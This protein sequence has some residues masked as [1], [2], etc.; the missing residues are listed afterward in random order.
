MALADVT[1]RND[2]LPVAVHRFESDV[3]SAAILDA[4]LSGDRA[5]LLIRDERKVVQ[6]RPLN[7]GDRQGDGDILLHDV[8]QYVICATRRTFVCMRESV[9]A[10]VS[11]CVCA[12]LSLSIPFSL[13]RSRGRKAG[14]GLPCS[15]D[16][17]SQ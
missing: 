2:L 11:V 5:F 1:D 12:S 8:E 14:E 17:I 15:W 10:C 7:R 16:S 9:C 13:C 4:T 3:S 6:I